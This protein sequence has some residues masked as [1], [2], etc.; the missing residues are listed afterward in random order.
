MASSLANPAD[1]VPAI[2]DRLIGAWCERRALIPLRYILQGYPLAWNVAD[3][4]H[5]LLQAMRDVRDQSQET[6]TDDEYQELVRAIALLLNTLE[7]R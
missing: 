1:D 7:K 6:L 3:Q 5:Q 4:R 2:L